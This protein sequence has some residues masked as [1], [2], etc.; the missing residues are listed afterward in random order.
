LV[1]T[2]ARYLL[3]QDSQGVIASATMLP[4]PETARIAAIQLVAVGLPVPTPVA[5][6]ET[7]Q[8]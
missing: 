6:E 5:T 3:R 8:G 4:L 1:R 2:A 7:D